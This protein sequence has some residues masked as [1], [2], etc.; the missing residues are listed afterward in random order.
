MGKPDNRADQQEKQNE[1]GIFQHE[2]G[3]GVTPETAPSPFPNTGRQYR[4][5]MSPD[6]KCLTSGS[7]LIAQTAGVKASMIHRVFLLPR[8]FGG[9]F[10]STPL[11]V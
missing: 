6:V 2:R 7:F 8:R 4:C 10:L 1:L 5:P 3:H 9:V 11:I